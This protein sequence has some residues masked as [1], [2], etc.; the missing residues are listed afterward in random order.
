MPPIGALTG[1]LR[2]TLLFLILAVSGAAL[3]NED[4]GFGGQ[5]DRSSAIEALLRAPQT[6]VIGNLHGHDI[7]FEY[8][9][10]R[11]PFCREME[12]AMVKMRA[13]DSELRLVLKPWPIFGPDSDYAARVAIAAS[14]LGKLSAFHESLFKATG[15]LDQQQVRELARGADLDMNRLA[16]DLTARQEELGNMLASDA[17]EARALALKGTPG[18]VIGRQIVRGAVTFDDL[19]SLIHEQYPHGGD[20]DRHQ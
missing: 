17:T 16:S 11:C 15:P 3:A 2:S 12:P 5:Q 14:W 20:L 10:Y 4:Y 1:F 6:L 8:Y 19:R 9:D 18:L 7:V 13:E